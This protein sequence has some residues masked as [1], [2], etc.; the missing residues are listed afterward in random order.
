M[1]VIG[2]CSCD[3]SVHVPD[4]L[5]LIIV[6]FDH[7]SPYHEQD[8]H[9]SQETL[10]IVYGKSW[11]DRITMRR[12]IDRVRAA[13]D[14]AQ[15]MSLVKHG[16]LTRTHLHEIHGPSGPSTAI[17][18]ITQTSNVNLWKVKGYF[19]LMPTHIIR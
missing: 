7:V 13:D 8:L 15:P 17:S 12:A 6:Q 10:E 14:R 1:Y 3:R 18:A 2:M 5:R 4:V 19:V 9:G 16:A 11:E